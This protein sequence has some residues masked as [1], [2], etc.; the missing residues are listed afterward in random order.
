MRWEIAGWGHLDP[1]E[2]VQ[3]I[4]M[5][6]LCENIGTNRQRK[7]ILEGVRWGYVLVD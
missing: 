2:G 7:D 5:G 6:F 3:Y 4:S 1:D